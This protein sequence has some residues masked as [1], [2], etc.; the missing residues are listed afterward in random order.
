MPA[1]VCYEELTG[2]SFLV[3]YDDGDRNRLLREEQIPPGTVGQSPKDGL[4]SA[5]FVEKAV[6]RLALMNRRMRDRD[7]F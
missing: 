5:G 1:L 7:M 6:A 4:M 2:R 3:C